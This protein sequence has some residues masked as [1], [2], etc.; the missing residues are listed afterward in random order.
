MNEDSEMELISIELINP[1]KQKVE[2][3]MLHYGAELGKDFGRLGCSTTMIFASEGKISDGM[4]VNPEMRKQI[5]E[6]MKDFLENYLE[7][8][9]E[10]LKKPLKV[11]E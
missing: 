8:F 9:S 10:E 5:V 3:L 7:E 2:G 4:V 6:F 1:Q 11:D